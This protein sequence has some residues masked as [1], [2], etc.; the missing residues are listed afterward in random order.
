[1]SLSEGQ[2]VPRFKVDENLPAEAVDA[3]RLAGYDA[4]TVLDQSL[5]GK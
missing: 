2:S 3:P 1:M 4:L 5:G